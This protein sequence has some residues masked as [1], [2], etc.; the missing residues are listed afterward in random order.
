MYTPKKMRVRKDTRE[1][2]TSPALAQK[3]MRDKMV[4]LKQEHMYVLLLDAGHRVVEEV[5]AAIGG[6][7]HVCV[8]PRAIFRRAI[9]LNASSVVLLHN[10]PSGDPTPSKQDGEL[11]V[12]FQRAG[13]LLGI[14]VL[15]HI[16][17]AKNGAVSIATTPVWLSAHDLAV[18]ASMDVSVI[19]LAHFLP[20]MGNSEKH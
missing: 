5:L 2:L 7:E 13:S 14:T 16:V 12:R 19:R 3:R 8:D 20:M 1:P 6:A 18:Y 17:M 10:H 15:D 9:E 11:T 4:D